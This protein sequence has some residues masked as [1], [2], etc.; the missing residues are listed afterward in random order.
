MT[1]LKLNGNGHSNGHSNGNG[2]GNGNGNGHG[3]SAL[4]I[5]LLAVAVVAVALL[6]FRQAQRFAGPTREVWVASGNLAPG[7]LLSPGDFQRASFRE[8]DLPQDAVEAD[9]E[10]DLQGRQLVRP[11]QEG[12]PFV[13]GDV[14][15]PASP[16]QR[17]ASLAELLPEGR[18]LTTV[19]VEVMTVLMHELRFG[20]RFELVAANGGSAARVVASDAYFLA[21]IDPAL[22]A[23]N[24]RRPEASEQPRGGF[25]ASLL[26]TPPELMNRGGGGVAASSTNLLLGLYPEDVLAVKQAEAG[27]R[28]SL[29]LHGKREVEEGRLLRIP[30]GSTSSVELIAGERRESVP[31]S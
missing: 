1:K 17:A 12:E 26:S 13:Q 31:V 30:S 19:R 28:L 18:V 10:D 2:H 4:K 11:K 24:Q 16:E 22:L 25:L 27:A 15:T 14:T 20:D 29:V 9:S 6:L 8:S 3:S 5:A 21:W 23:Q 7:V